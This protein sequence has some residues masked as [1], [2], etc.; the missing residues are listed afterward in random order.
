MVLRWVDPEIA[1]RYGNMVYVR[2]GTT[3]D[4]PVKKR[5]AK[6]KTTTAV[7]AAPPPPPPPGAPK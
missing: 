5:P 1:G 3:P 7:P 4:K 6:K 2:C